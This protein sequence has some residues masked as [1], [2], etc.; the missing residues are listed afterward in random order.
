MN[1]NTGYHDDKINKVNYVREGV[2]EKLRQ[3]YLKRDTAVVD[4]LLDEYN[5]E[6]S[7]IHSLQMEFEN[8][9]KE[10]WYDE[11]LMDGNQCLI[12]RIVTR[13]LFRQDLNIQNGVVKCSITWKES[14]S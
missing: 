9:D 1:I 8:I 7:L 2:S 5:M 10:V 11:N 3:I 4:A 6:N 12:D 13:V 14:S